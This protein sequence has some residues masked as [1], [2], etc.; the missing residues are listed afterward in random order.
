MKISQKKPCTLFYKQNNGDGNSIQVNFNC[1]LLLFSFTRL[2][3][4]SIEWMLSAALNFKI[5]WHIRYK[6]PRFLVIYLLTVWIWMNAVKINTKQFLHQWITKQVK[7][8]CW[9]LLLFAKMCWMPWWI[10]NMCDVIRRKRASFLINEL[11]FYWW[12]AKLSR[13]LFVWNKHSLKCQKLMK[14][15]PINF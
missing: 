1:S 15:Q 3:C 11:T 7:S 4:K 8:C 6:N 9:W 14:L 13:W 2:P 10:F 12:S 5:L